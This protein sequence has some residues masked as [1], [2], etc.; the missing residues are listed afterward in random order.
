MKFLNWDPSKGRKE[1]IESLDNHFIGKKSH[2]MNLR[3]VNKLALN[4][5]YD[6]RNFLSFIERERLPSVLDMLTPQAKFSSMRVSFTNRIAS[7]SG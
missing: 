3:R 7:L 6:K 5:S 1:L 2:E 4:A